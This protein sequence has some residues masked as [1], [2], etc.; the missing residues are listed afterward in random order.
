MKKR[1]L[2]LKKIFIALFALI[3]LIVLS[4]FVV[5]KINI[6][7]VSNDDT[8]ITFKVEKNSTFYSISNDLKEN[9]LIK[10]QFFYKIYLKLNKPTE[11]KAGV[12]NLSK[13]MSVDEIIG[14]LTGDPDYSYGSIMVTFKEGINMRKVAKTIEEVTDYTYEE[15]INASNDK[16]MLK[17][18]IDEYWFL[19]DDILNENIYYGLEGYLFPDTYQIKAD[20]DIKQIFKVMLDNLELKLEPYKDDIKNN[21]YS[22]HEIITMAS[23]V[24][25]EASLSDDRAGVAG[26]FYNRLENKWSL[27]SDV[28]TYYAIK[29]EMNERDLYKSE[30]NDYNSYNTRSSKMAGKLPVGPICNPGLDS[31]KA[32]INPTSHNYFYFVADKNKKTYFTK[33]NSEHLK[34]VS[35]LKKEGLWYEY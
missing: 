10:S 30:L 27:G 14:I 3:I 31:I 15:V 7:K 21:K 13:N 25:L 35:Q 5:Y 23:I 4:L 20:M 17:E 26:V 34:K 24:E 18:L 2:S 29:V 28:T 22:I 16:K 8:L 6:G 11:L 1:K 33:T 12:Y 9:D 32:T 19:T